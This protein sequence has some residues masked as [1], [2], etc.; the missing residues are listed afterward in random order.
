[1]SALAAAGTIS[2]VIATVCWGVD[3]ATRPPCP[4]RYVRLIDF[5]IVLP[6]ITGLLAV[7]SGLLWWSAVRR[8]KTKVQIWSVVFA[9]VLLV[10]ALLLFIWAV[11]TLMAHHGQVVDSN[12]W[13]F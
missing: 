8:R 13:T 2:A 5:E 7:S 10:L 9:T 1:M 4:E 11:S 12:C 6:G 3:L